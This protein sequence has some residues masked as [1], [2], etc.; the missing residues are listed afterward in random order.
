MAGYNEDAFEAVC[1]R[2]RLTQKQIDEFRDLLHQ[3]KGQSGRGGN[4]NLTY[5]ELLE[6]A[7]QWFNL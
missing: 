7:Q 6:L 1:Q 4:D 5:Q 3:E 2:L